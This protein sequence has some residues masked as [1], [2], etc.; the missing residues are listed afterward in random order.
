MIVEW[1]LVIGLTKI[2]LIEAQ[3]LWFKSVHISLLGMF[4]KCLWE[5]YKWKDVCTLEHFILYT[6]RSI[7]TRNHC[8]VMLVETHIHSLNDYYLD[9]AENRFP[10]DIDGNFR[11]FI[12]RTLNSCLKMEKRME[13]S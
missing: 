6:L 4:L 11:S 9:K 10:Y 7:P 8:L 12:L 5:V 1:T 2:F 13:L 3:W